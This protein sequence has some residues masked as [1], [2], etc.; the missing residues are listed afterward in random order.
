MK[1]QIKDM[2][3]YAWA[4]NALTHVTTHTMGGEVE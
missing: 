2:P 3:E 4:M 1:A